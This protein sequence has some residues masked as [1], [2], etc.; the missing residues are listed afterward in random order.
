MLVIGTVVGVSDA[1]V[2]IDETVGVGLS[3]GSCVDVAGDVEVDV[4]GDV[5]GDVDVD[6]DVAGDVAV[7]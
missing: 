3:D 2:V 7:S 5:A 4:A 1:T 6:V